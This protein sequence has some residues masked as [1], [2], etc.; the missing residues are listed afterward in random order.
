MSVPEYVGRIKGSITI[1]LYKRELEGG[2]IPDKWLPPDLYDL[3]TVAEFDSLVKP[4][5]ILINSL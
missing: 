3:A 1:E 4:I 5:E 2:H